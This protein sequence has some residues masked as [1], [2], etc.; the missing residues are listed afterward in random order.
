MESMSYDSNA[1]ATHL[2]WA[3]RTG[4]KIGDLPFGARPG[5]LEEGYAAQAIFINRTNEQVVGWKIAG[6][7]PRGLRGELPSAPAHGCLTPS[8][9]IKS[10]SV[11]RFP[12]HTKATL[13]TEVA[14]RFA[15]S[16]SPAEE[17]FNV[18]AM[19]D[20]AFVAIE[21]VCSRFID[22]KAVGQPSFV[23]DNLGFHAL[24]C[25]DRV[26]FSENCSFEDEAGV[27]RNG[28]RI[29]GSLAGEDRTRPFD[30]LAF[31]WD[32]FARQRTVIPAAAIVTT[33]TL[34]VPVDIEGP[35]DFRARLG[36]RTVDIKFRLPHEEACQALE[37]GRLNV[38]GYDWLDTATPFQQT[39]F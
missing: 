4:L 16:V 9:V 10:A 32:Q 21:V 8:R 28:E 33:G 36:D 6:A 31:L 7:S 11:L 25:G 17:P 34:S 15:R 37:L 22:R 27:W 35:G 5:S 2:E 38:T 24:V 12:S 39:E 13:E 23:A 30:S 29:A 19:I 1:A 3:S 26:D 14:F 18:S 20:Q